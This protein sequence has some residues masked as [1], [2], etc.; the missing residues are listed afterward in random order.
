VPAAIL[1]AD[2]DAFYAS[3]AQRDD[4]TLRGR[5]VVV[6]EG[7]VLAASYEARAFGV[8]S[9]MGGRERR[10]R[11]PQAVVVAPDWEACSAASRAVREVLR[12]TGA[13]V[14]PVSVDEAFLDVGGLGRPARDVAEEVRREVRAQVGLPIT[15]GGGATRLIA[16]MAGAAAKPDGLRIVE[17]EEERAF[18]HPLPLTALWGLGPRSAEK[19]H[20]RGWRTIGDLA[21]LEERELVAVL[22]RGQGR[23]VHALAHNREVRSV[24]PPRRGRRSFGAQSARRART[25]AEADDAL[26]HVVERVSARMA[27]AGRVGRTVVLRVRFADFSRATR[28]VTMPTATAAAPTLLAAG[29]D[30]LAEVLP[31]ELTLVGITVTNLELPAPEGQLALHVGS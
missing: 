16:K 5:P 6:G 24:R 13:V 30:L 11:C 17:P 22:G 28:S 7:V 8:R 21:E 19:L 25:R 2:L 4:P 31:A 9:A 3:V 18:L 12:A 10:R 23:T 20:A 14:R 26:R 27:R 1:H 29:R 15:V